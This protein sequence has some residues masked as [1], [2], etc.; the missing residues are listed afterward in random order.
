LKL[1]SES[2]DVILRADCVI[3][4]PYVPEKYKGKNAEIRKFKRNF[5]K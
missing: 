4:L 1:D 5:K 2:E 3:P